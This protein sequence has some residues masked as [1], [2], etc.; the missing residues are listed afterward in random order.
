MI[1]KY[2]D[3]TYPQGKSIHFAICGSIAFFKVLELIRYF[4]NRDISVSCSLTRSA[5]EFVSPLTFKAIG[6][7][8]VQVDMFSPNEVYSHLYPGLDPEVYV[9]APA[10]ANIMAKF[11]NGIADDLVSTQLLAFNKK[12]IFAPAMNPRMYNAKQTQKNIQIITDMGAEI[13]LPDSG[14]VACGES[15]TGRLADILYI[16]FRILKAITPQDLEGLKVL[17]TLGPTREFFDPVR[18]W[19]NPSSGKMG[20]ALAMAAWLRGA[21]VTCVSGPTNLWLPPEIKIIKVVSARDMFEA[22]LNKWQESTIG[23]LCAAVCDFR[24][25]SLHTQKFKKDSVKDSLIV[26]FEKN[27]DILA[28][29]GKLKSNKQILIGFAAETDKNYMELAMDKIKRKN[30]DWIVANKINELDVG[31]AA[32]T[33]EVVIID[34]YGRIQSLNKMPKSDVAWKILDLVQKR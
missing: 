28:N 7:D 16:Y 26:E 25:K 6:C 12:I 18:F 4:I 3:F 30:L 32:D 5:Q 24:P 17:I 31:F 33:N 2:L 22:T 13:I 1:P 10:T 11:A 20:A 29:L 21:H 8:P 19:S 27:P 9:V 23:I 15:G 34:K 14:N